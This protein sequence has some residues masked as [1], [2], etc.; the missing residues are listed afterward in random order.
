MDPM[1]IEMITLKETINQQHMK[2][3]GAEYE[4]T[5]SAVQDPIIIRYV[6]IRVYTSSKCKAMSNI[7]HSETFHQGPKLA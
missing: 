2:L 3:D 5:S 4:A 1:A 7:M 6:I